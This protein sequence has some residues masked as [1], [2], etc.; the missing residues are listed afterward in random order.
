MVM[1]SVYFRSATPPT[2]IAETEPFRGLM[3]KPW[4]IR[5][6]M[7]ADLPGL[8]PPRGFWRG[9][10]RSVLHPADV[11]HEAVKTGGS[12]QPVPAQLGRPRGE[13]GSATFIEGPGSDSG[14]IEDGFVANLSGHH[15]PADLVPVLELSFHFVLGI[16]FAG[17]D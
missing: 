4:Y 13:A 14:C 3:E 6:V 17:V 10:R 5:D 8:G 2:R 1:M 7:R 16:E 15:G 9:S 11:V 12:H